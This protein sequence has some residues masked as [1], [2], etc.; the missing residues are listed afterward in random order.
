MNEACT[1]LLCLTS[2]LKGLL[3]RKKVNSELTKGNKNK[4]KNDTE[5]NMASFTV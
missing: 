4:N 2:P 1:V 5:W 3:T